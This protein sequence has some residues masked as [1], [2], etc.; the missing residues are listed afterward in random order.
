MYFDDIVNN[1]GIIPNDTFANGDFEGLLVDFIDKV[2]FDGYFLFNDSTS[3][4]VNVA[5]SL[6]AAATSY[7]AI[8]IS[9]ADQ[10][11]ADQLGLSL[12][13]DVRNVNEEWLLGYI[14]STSVSLGNS[15]P[16][17]I[18]FSNRIAD[19]QWANKSTFLAD[20]SGIFLNYELL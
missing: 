3:D 2:K 13:L 19:L 7:N 16:V 15:N 20:Y 8:A 14:N 6:S 10:T 4:S 1:Y 18:S 17:S 11:I 5:I 12:I 9:E